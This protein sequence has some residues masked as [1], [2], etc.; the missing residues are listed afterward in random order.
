MAITFPDPI[1]FATAAHARGQPALARFVLLSL[2]LHAAIVLIL[3]TSHG[4]GAGNADRSIDVLD[5]TL[6]R[7][8][9]TAAPQPSAAA[10][11]RPAPAP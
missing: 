4:G 10:E 8:A 5:V 2:L 6:G 9:Q 11:E 3:G 1:R 7:P